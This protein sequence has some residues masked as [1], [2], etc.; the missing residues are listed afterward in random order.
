MLGFL[1]KHFCFAISA[2]CSLSLVILDV[3][4]HM[5]MIIIGFSP[6]TAGNCSLSCTLLGYYAASS[7]NF[8]PTFQDNVL[9]PSS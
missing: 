6:N 3:C 1:C 8:L 4:G 9:F 2:S 7:R 5:K